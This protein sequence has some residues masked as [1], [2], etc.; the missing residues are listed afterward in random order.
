MTETNDQI[1]TSDI[2]GAA[3]VPA[4]AEGQQE[5]RGGRGEGTQKERPRACDGRARQ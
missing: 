3:D 1:Q 5:R 2:P 4:A